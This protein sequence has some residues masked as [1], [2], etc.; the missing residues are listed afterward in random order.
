MNP[1]LDW[2]ALGSTLREAALDAH[3]ELPHFDVAWDFLLN[4][5][6][7]FDHANG[8]PADMPAEPP[9]ELLRAYYTPL[10]GERTR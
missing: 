2:D 1:P 6:E 4:N 5:P 10:E 7:C 8:W 3:D 9:I